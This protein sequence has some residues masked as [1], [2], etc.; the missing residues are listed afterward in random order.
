MTTKDEFPRVEEKM[1]ELG[2]WGFQ[3]A[4]WRRDALLYGEKKV[5]QNLDLPRVR[6]KI[7]IF[8]IMVYLG[9]PI[10]LLLGLFSLYYLSSVDPWFPFLD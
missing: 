5:L 3:K 6:R 1:N 8:K 10:V 7:Q 4:E 2:M 9:V